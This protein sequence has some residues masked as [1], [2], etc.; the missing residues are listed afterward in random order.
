MGI[1]NLVQLTNMNT[2]NTAMRYCLCLLMAYV[3]DESFN[4]MKF[5][6]RCKGTL[7]GELSELVIHSLTLNTYGPINQ[8]T[9]YIIILAVK[10]WLIF[11]ICIDL[12]F[13][14]VSYV[15]LSGAS[16]SSTLIFL[17]SFQ[18]FINEILEVIS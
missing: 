1:F 9:S 12:L 13:H 8:Y 10:F 2:E 17:Y 3:I 16:Y 18:R 11:D 4:V 5:Y 6:H 14:S 15:H 7:S